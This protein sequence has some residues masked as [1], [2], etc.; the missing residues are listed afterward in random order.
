MTKQTFSNRLAE[1]ILQK[2]NA[3]CVGLDPRF[4]LLPSELKILT[5]S[6]G[7]SHAAV[8][9]KFCYEVLDIVSP[10]VPIVKP[11]IAFFERHGAAGMQSLEAVVQ[12]AQ[13]LGLVVILDGKRNDI[14]S[15]AEAYASAYLGRG[16]RSA[17][18]GDALTVSPYLGDDTLEPFVDR[19]VARQAGMFVLVK[20]SN[21]GS[22]FLQDL[23][24]DH[25]SIA[26]R[27]AAWVEH[28]S[29]A[30]RGDDQLGPVGAV[31][32]A[33][34]PNELA[35]M[36]QKMPSAWILIPGYGSQG[37]TA[38]DVA[39]GFHPNGLGAIVNASRSII[40]AFDREEFQSLERDWRD[41]I[42]KATTAMIRDMA[43]YV[44]SPTAV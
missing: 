3:V 2:G 12:R 13:S 20:T 31:V 38:Q 6:S 14:G 42:H 26:E 5:E 39:A 41:S 16:R 18:G 43:K 17:F 4:S 32:G 44:P 35:Q 1:A 15:T 30:L 21:P 27:I 24:I 34:Y 36:R 10:L 19:C 8:I 29:S 25:Q 23:Q 40:Y 33:T 9:R 28:Q 11:Q 37:G 22:G 7:L